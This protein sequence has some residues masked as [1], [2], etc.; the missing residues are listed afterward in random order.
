MVGLQLSSIV[1]IKQSKQ[2]ARLP[3]V[4]EAKLSGCQCS[5]PQDG[6]K[7]K[8]ICRVCKRSVFNYYLRAL[9][10]IGPPV[11]QQ[12]RHKICQS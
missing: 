1:S 5:G 11:C 2:E 3:K 9:C 6:T 12:N 4:F 7:S 8:R 10:W